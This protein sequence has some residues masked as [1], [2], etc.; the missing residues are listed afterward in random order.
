MID[1]LIAQSAQGTG[2]PPDKARFALASALSLMDRHA[3][4]KK[5][6]D[7]YAGVPDARALSA[8][9]PAPK[10]AG[11]LMG[12]MM[13]LGGAS[14]AALSDAMAMNGAL[15][16]QGVTTNHLKKLLPLA[17]EWVKAKT[18]RDLLGE[19]MMSIP[20]VGALMSGKGGEAKA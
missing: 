2:L 14:G 3:D 9:A 6:A 11:G 4:Q 1:D 12:G 20:G 13:K 17:C 8:E 19:A 10:K 5:M 16:A 7:L 18:G 15:T